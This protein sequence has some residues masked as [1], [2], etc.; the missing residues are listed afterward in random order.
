MKKSKA[1]VTL[2]L[3]AFV[4]VTMLFA[5]CKTTTPTVNLKLAELKAG[6][7]TLVETDGK[8]VHS[9]G[10]EVGSLTLS[11]TAKDSSATVEGTGEKTLTVGKNEF[12]VTV[13]KSGKTA[14]YAV[15]ITR[16]AA[17]LDLTE[18]KIGDNVLTAG[19]DGAY[20]LN[21]ENSVKTITLSATA[22][23]SYVE[24]E[25]L[26]E[27][28]LAVGENTFTITVKAGD[29]TK[30]Y[31]V[32]VV[33]AAAD[34]TL[35]E[36]K[37]G[38]TVLTAGADGV[39]K[40]N[41]ENEVT[42]TTLSVRANNEN[43]TITGAGSKTLNVGDNTFEIVVSVGE[44]K[45]K[46]TVVVNRAKSDVKT[47]EEI[48]VN[49]TSV[50]YDEDENA[51]VITVND[52]TAKVAV[53]LTSKV[54]SYV[55]DPEVG[56]L[57]EGD[58]EFEITVTAENGSEATYVLVIKLVLPTYSVTYAGNIGGAVTS[59]T[60]TY[61]H[62][63]AQT[64]N[65]TLD[66]K[67]TQSYG[68]ITVTYKVG[69]G[70][71]K[72]AVLDDNYGFT[73]PAEEAIGDIVVTVSGIEI[74]V[75]TVTY[76]KG[77]ATTTEKVKHGENATGYEITPNTESKEVLDGYVYTHDEKWV[78]EENGMTVASF[79]N[80]TEDIDVYYK[81]E[82]LVS[83]DV[84]YY[85]PMGGAI[86]YYTIRQMNAYVAGGQNGDVIF[87]VLV[88]SLATDGT[89]EEA[90]KTSFVIYGTAT[91]NPANELGVSVSESELNKWFTVKATAADKKVTVYNPDGAVVAEKTFEAY[92]ADT[93]SL[94]M[95]ADV[96]VAAVN[97]TVPEICTVTYLDEN[98]DE[99]HSEKVFKGG[100]ASEYDYSKPDEDLG[101]GYTRRYLNAE[102]VDENGEAVNFDSIQ[103]DITV[104]I[105]FDK[106]IVKTVTPS[107]DTK[108]SEINR[109]ISVDEN[110]VVT[111][112]ILV[113]GGWTG[114]NVLAKGGFVGISGGLTPDGKWLTVTVN[115]VDGK[116]TITDENGV[117]KP[118]DGDAY[119]AQATT[120]AD[121]AIRTTAGN[122]ADVAAINP[123][124]VNMEFYDTDK[125]TLLKTELVVKGSINYVHTF[126][127]DS[128][129][130]TKTVDTWALVEGSEN[131]VYA[132]GGTYKKTYSVTGSASGDVVNAGKYIM[133]YIDVVANKI[134]VYVTLYA[135]GMS[136]G[137]MEY[138]NWSQPLQTMNCVAGKTYKLVMNFDDDGNGLTASL[139]DENGNVFDGKSDIDI[140]ACTTD[141]FNFVIKTPV[142][143]WDPL[144]YEDSGSCD[145][146][147][148]W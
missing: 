116:I 72:T 23:K 4:F 110:G 43:A 85:E 147:V 80:I 144:V 1:K 18:V 52:K 148:R 97:P 3:L 108:I 143:T 10:Y 86:T 138:T 109:F 5:A 70:A 127:T 93:I 128:E 46:Y 79:D 55:I 50:D 115:T 45:T 112:G 133:K 58:N 15:E 101:N 124:I 113:K 39:Y 135:G 131:K 57:K 117:A 13:S 77:G 25:G 28:T 139:F 95:H 35:A 63:N 81:D 121:I 83:R 56:T 24:I 17:V 60:F 51:Y 102:W 34:L 132:S 146:A 8:Y 37:I 64:L 111:F 137:V 7:V 30:N 134:E 126:E 16:A 75:Y 74:N 66:G 48:T 31:T 14:V 106:Y 27:K 98:G 29:A 33:R 140:S 122:E 119:T 40:H 38:D 73:V 47:I 78:T 96:K 107:S 53:T 32:K 67:Y 118:L 71:E 68:K 89:P 49:G 130:Y 76:H 129:G 12:T 94:A 125:T 22:A 141:K 9:V 142:K 44:E 104:N 84:K 19:A 120:L 21:V 103:N 92:A 2:V 65:V 11:A 136:L 36:V 26:G 91:Y 69:N 61:K 82:I 20:T 105:F 114:L 59:E 145:I 87:K 99:I 62:G 88:K 100:A 42:E 41:V 90:G 54:A 123:D 6:D